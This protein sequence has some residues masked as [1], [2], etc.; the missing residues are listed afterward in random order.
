MDCV[1]YSKIYVPSLLDLW[2]SFTFHG[3][4]GS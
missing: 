1:Y 3:G 4:G 2:E